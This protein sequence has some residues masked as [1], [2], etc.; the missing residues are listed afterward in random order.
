MHTEVC[1]GVLLHLVVCVGLFLHMVAC[2]RILLHMN[3]CGGPWWPVVAYG[4]YGG[5]LWLMEHMVAYLLEHM[6]GCACIFS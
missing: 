5:L 2:G 4:A 6:V 3:A 1:C